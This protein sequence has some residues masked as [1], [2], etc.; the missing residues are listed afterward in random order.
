M[1]PPKDAKTSLADS[2]LQSGEL[3]FNPGLPEEER[4]LNKPKFNALIDR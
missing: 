1:D 3:A 4:E 2:I